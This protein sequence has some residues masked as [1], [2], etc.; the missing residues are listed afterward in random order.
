MELEAGAVAAADRKKISVLKRP[1]A[2]I[3][4][5]LSWR[6]GFL[7]FHNTP[8]IDAVAEFNRYH[9]RQVIIQDPS[10]AEIPVSGNFRAGNFDAFTR[11][12][13]LGFQI[14]IT[15]EDDRILLRSK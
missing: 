1:L 9:T 12:L 11:L 5:T 10:L 3:E 15:Q 13:Q 8:L 6:S 4:E 14:Q 7:V 2:E